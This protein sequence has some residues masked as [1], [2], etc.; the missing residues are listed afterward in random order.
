M[1]T[2]QNLTPDEAQRITEHEAVKDDVRRQVHAEI[3]RDA[4]IAPGDRAAEA[5]AADA[6]RQRA[7]TEVTTTEREI[8]RGRSVARGSQV[9]DY[10]FYLVYGVIGLA[11]ALHAIGAR[12]SAGFMRFVDALAYPFVAPFRG[13]MQDPA[14]GSFRFLLSYVVALAVYLL[15]H[16]A[17]NGLLRIFTERKTAI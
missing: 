14:V 9:I 6:L 3:A 12:E 1:A 7:V 13:I 11:I 4:R 16:V 17:V 2:Q 8:S 5:T 15:L 10:L